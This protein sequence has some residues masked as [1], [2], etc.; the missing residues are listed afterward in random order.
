MGIV[1]TRGA[2][3]GGTVFTHAVSTCT[4]GYPGF[5][6][7]L[8]VGDTIVSINTVDATALTHTGE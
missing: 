8:R 6:G 7:N 1:S 2:E 5:D 4:E 3:D